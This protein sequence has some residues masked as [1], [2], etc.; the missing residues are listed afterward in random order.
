MSDLKLA[1]VELFE[2]GEYSCYFRL[3]KDKAYL[4]FIDHPTGTD[5]FY[6]IPLT[7]P[8][9][10]SALE[11]LSALAFVTEKQFPN[12][13]FDARTQDGKKLHIPKKQAKAVLDAFAAELDNAPDI[14]KTIQQDDGL[15]VRPIIINE[16][17]K[18]QPSNGVAFGAADPYQERMNRFRYEYPEA[19]PPTRDWVCK[20]CGSHEKANTYICKNCG[21]GHPDMWLCPCFSD[22]Y[23]ARAYASGI[24]A[25]WTRCWKCHRLRPDYVPE[26]RRIRLDGSP[27]YHL[28]LD[29]DS[30]LLEVILTQYD[31][32]KY[33]F[34]DK[35]PALQSALN[36]I[37]PDLLT[38][39]DDSG[40][41]HQITYSSCEK[42][43][44]QPDELR[45]I[46]SELTAKLDADKEHVKAWHIDPTL[47]RL[48]LPNEK[49]FGFMLRF[50]SGSCPPLDH[51]LPYINEDDTW[52]C[53]CRLL[54]NRFDRCCRCGALRPGLTEAQVQPIT[55]P[56][57]VTPPKP[58]HTLPYVYEDGSWDCLCGKGKITGK[59]CC[60]CGAERPD[61]KPL[62]T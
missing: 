3:L 17:K 31:T 7:H 27:G 8:C 40:F 44:V 37:T 62:Q 10:L 12:E 53:A 35:H 36:Q 28:Y 56:Q 25:T 34:S 11:K 50:E 4:S 5:T 26:I 54:G 18:S 38:E 52:D 19:I 58:K 43:S 51:E 23:V 57:P 13:H 15:I 42:V 59:F 41:L 24:A 33:Q 49:S 2:Y 14:T 29:G 1:G 39:Q 45:R 16:S 9:L 21:A 6:D 48:V 61:A 20:Y 55:S 47:T 30:T 46:L 22:D 60:E 32:A